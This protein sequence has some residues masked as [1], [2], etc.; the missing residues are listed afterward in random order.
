M[1]LLCE[2]IEFIVPRVITTLFHI[3]VLAAAVLLC[4]NV[5]IGVCNV[6]RAYAIRAVFAVKYLLLVIKG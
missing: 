1:G 2:V 6:T 4:R 3:V 5:P